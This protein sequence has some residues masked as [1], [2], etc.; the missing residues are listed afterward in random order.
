MTA[1]IIPYAFSVDGEPRVGAVL[2]IYI[3]DLETGF[4]VDLDTLEATADEGEAVFDTMIGSLS[5][6]MPPDMGTE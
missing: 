5:F 1:S 6:F 4:L 2:A 3:P